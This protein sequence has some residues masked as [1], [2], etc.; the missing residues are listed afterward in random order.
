MIGWPDHHYVRVFPLGW[1]IVQVRP[2][3]ARMSSKWTSVESILSSR[4]SETLW[5]RV[6]QLSSVLI[7][8]LMEKTNNKRLLL[9]NSLHKHSPSVWNINKLWF[10]SKRRE[11]LFSF[12]D[13]FR[14]C[15]LTPYVVFSLHRT[16]FSSGPNWLWDFCWSVLSISIYFVWKGIDQWKLLSFVDRIGQCCPAAARAT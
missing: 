13:L 14:S 2:S 11:R 8:A 16:A 5:W 10:H 6:K 15:L 1:Q 4:V 9:I 12:G 3:R 7:Y